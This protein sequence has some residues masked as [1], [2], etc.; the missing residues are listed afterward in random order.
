MKISRKAMFL[1]ILF[2]LSGCSCL[3]AL[4]TDTH[5]IINEFIAQ[6]EMKGFSLD[7]YLKA[8]LGFPKGIHEEFMA[9]WAALTFETNSVS[10]WMKKGGKGEDLP[11]GR[12]SA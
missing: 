4:E 1:T 2:Y 6:K 5:E 12:R 3:L 8:Q 7:T 9:S 11:S 10:T